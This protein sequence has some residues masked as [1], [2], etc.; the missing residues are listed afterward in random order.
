MFPMLTLL[1]YFVTEQVRFVQ[2]DV[3]KQTHLFL[4]TETHF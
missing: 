3:I 1:R 2:Y 4:R